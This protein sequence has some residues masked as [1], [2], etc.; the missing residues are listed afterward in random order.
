MVEEAIS[1]WLGTRLRTAH[2]RDSI[3]L[4]GMARTETLGSLATVGATLT[5]AL[6]WL[7]EEAAMFG[8]GRANVAV[9]LITLDSLEIQL[10]LYLP[11]NLLAEPRPAIVHFHGGGMVGGCSS[12]GGS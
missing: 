8:V 4:A 7:V 2:L 5:T 3:P 10:G 1:S 11:P 9:S 6:Q 12:S